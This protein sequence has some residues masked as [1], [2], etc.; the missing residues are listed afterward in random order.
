MVFPPGGTGAWAVNGSAAGTPSNPRQLSAI[1][2]GSSFWSEISIWLPASKR[3]PVGVG[4]MRD[5][6]GPLASP[7]R[8]ATIWVVACSDRVWSPWVRAERGTSGANAAVPKAVKTPRRLVRK[9]HST[10]RLMRPFL[11]G[12]VQ[13]AG[14]GRTRL[15]EAIFLLRGVGLML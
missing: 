2:T 9:F 14:R 11:A 12:N 5:H 7:A 13:P 10:M 6:V 4:P 3:T 1:G 8:R 15:H